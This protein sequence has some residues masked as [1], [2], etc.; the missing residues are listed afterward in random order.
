VQ[1]TRYSE[2]HVYLVFGTP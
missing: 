1:I 2:N